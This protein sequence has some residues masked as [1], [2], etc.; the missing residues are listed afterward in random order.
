MQYVTRE[1]VQAFVEETAQQMERFEGFVSRMEVLF[2]RVLEA[3]KVN[4]SSGA[5]IGRNPAPRTP[6][7]HTIGDGA[8]PGQAPVQ[9]S[10]AGDDGAS[11]F[12]EDAR[13]FIDR[14]SSI[15]AILLLFPL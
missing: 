9:P 15:V 13:S 14:T 4:E 12:N 5:R 7:L 3:L 2:E 8:S 10:A 11:N 1:E 6:T